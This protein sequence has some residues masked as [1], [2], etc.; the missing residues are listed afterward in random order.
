ME[1]G[2]RKRWYN[3]EISRWAGWP[4]FLLNATTA[5]MGHRLSAMVR[6]HGASPFM[7]SMDNDLHVCSS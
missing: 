1:E 3:A 4:G 2:W 6:H 7:G 5:C